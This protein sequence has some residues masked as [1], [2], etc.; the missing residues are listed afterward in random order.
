MASKPLDQYV[1]AR[2]AMPMLETARRMIEQIP[3][4]CSAGEG[5]LNTVCERIQDMLRKEMVQQLKVGQKAAAALGRE[6][7]R[8]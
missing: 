4:E 8:G 5:R 3:I 6:V 1:S 2:I 7:G